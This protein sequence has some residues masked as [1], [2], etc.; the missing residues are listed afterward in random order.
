[1]GWVYSSS[2]KS[3]KRC[4]Q[5]KMRWNWTR[6]TASV[7]TS[8]VTLYSY[9]VKQKKLLSASKK[10]SR[11]IQVYPKGFSTLVKRTR[12]TK[13]I[14]LHRWSKSNLSSNLN[15]QVLKVISGKE[16]ISINSK[17]NRKLRMQCYLAWNIILV[18]LLRI[19]L[20]QN[21]IRRSMKLRNLI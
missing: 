4:Y 18:T 13:G 12:S 20:Q 11:S 6:P 10:V 9:V 8:R 2:T 21:V 14:N 19:T 1:M 17:S 15:L 5:S 7:T 3:K 16:W